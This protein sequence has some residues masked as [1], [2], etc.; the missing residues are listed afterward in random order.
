MSDIGDAVGTA[1]EGGLFAKAIDQRRGSRTPLEK[2]HFAEGQCLNCGTELIGS[3]CHACGQKAHLH[4]TIGAFVHDLLHGALHFDGK[5]WRTLPL[6]AWKPGELTRR[7][8]DGERQRFVSPMALFLF[9]VFL[10]FAVFQAVGLTTPATVGSSEAAVIEIDSEREDLR[11]EIDV[12]E[13]ELENL[14]PNDTARDPIQAELNEVRQDMVVLD[15][16]RAFIGAEQSGGFT[17]TGK[18]GWALL[19]KV[20]DKWRENPGLMLYK[21][22]ANSYKFS[23]LLIPLSIPFVWLLFL[24]KRQFRAYD[25]AIFVT[26]SIAFMSLVFIAISLMEKIGLPETIW[27]TILIFLPPIHIYR[28]LRGTYGLRRRSALW[29]LA[30]LFVF[31]NIV[32]LLFLQI[33]VV[34]GAF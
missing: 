7:Y 11:E 12:L 33:L 10:M 19:D 4:R 9:A 15:S 29:R 2:G 31:I 14:A 30:V 17:P 20:N 32:A 24:W 3:H 27:G 8:I 18:S 34:L 13:T 23:W 26:Y 28:H 6:L 5:T 25:H 22:Q 1:V 21:L 16:A